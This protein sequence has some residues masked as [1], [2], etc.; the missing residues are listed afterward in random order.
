MLLKYVADVDAADGGGSTALH[1]A[2]RQYCPRATDKSVA[3]N[4]EKSVVDV[5][6]ENKADVN[7]AN[8]SG[9][10]PLYRGVSRES[11]DIVS[12]MLEECGGNPNKGS[13][14]KSPLVKACRMQSVELVDMLLKHGADPNLA[15]KS[16][17][18]DPRNQYSKHVHALPLLIAV[19]KGDSDIVMA[20]LNA[21]ANVNAVNREGNS[22]LRLAIEYLTKTYGRHNQSTEEMR[23]KLS[24][25]RLLL[26]R[27][28]SFNV[29]MPD[30]RS[31]LYLAI[32][33]LAEEEYS[34]YRGYVVDL[35][36]LIIKYDSMQLDFSRLPRHIYHQSL[37]FGPLM[38]LATFDGRHDFIL[39]MFRAGAGVGL[40]AFCCI[41]AATA[42]FEVKSI[43]L[44]QAAVLAGYTP[45]TEELGHLNDIA[46][47]HRPT[48]YL[49]QQLVIWLNEDR[50]QVP[51][52]L[53]RCR[54]VIRR[55]LSV[56]VHFQSILPAID[57]LP[58]PTA[59]KLYLQFDGPKTEVDLG[60]NKELQNRETTEN[61]SC[62]LLT[63]LTIVTMIFTIIIYYAL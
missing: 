11:L 30:G 4:I 60:V 63:V 51:S 52:L 5:L 1:H 7:K 26:Q 42:H 28:A 29:P 38:A 43:S 19:D 59:L 55:K 61:V 50:Q 57:K 41:A 31:P 3:M 53:R 48:A 36:E 17:H 14:D 39:D 62:Y 13:L 22:A 45:N 23:N 25:T 40:T 18:S 32:T 2:V 58:L 44:C 8:K 12:K 16:C 37:Y 47:G 33:A 9:E 56:A 54:V 49:S 21:G 15:L 6:L 34:Q 10:T 24:V 46:A 20:L 27:G 35:L